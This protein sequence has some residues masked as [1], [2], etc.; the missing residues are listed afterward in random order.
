MHDD[1]IDTAAVDTDTAEEFP[2]TMRRRERSFGLNF[3]RY[4]QAAAAAAAVT[5]RPS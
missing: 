2:T 5:I 3:R 1:G 4:N